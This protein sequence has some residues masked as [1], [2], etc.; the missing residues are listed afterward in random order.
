MEYIKKYLDKKWLENQYTNGKSVSK[1]AKECGV[2]ITT[3]SRWLDY[4][5]I[6]KLRKSNVDRRGNKNPFWSGG[7]YIDRLNGYVSVYSPDHPFAKKKGYV[8][9]HR[10]VMEKFLGR[11]LR[12]N[13]IVHHRN[14]R[15]TDN[16]I[17]NLE[18]IVIG[19]VNG[20]DVMCPHCSKI[21]KLS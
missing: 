5:N 10:L 9:E 1:I 19:D 11:Y 20:G 7:K 17:E 16:R 8:Q 2:A 4:F 18:L 21:F 6:R 13:E 12:R 3:V 14:K 15:K